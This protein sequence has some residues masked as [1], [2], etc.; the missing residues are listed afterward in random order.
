MAQKSPQG[1]K[2]LSVARKPSQDASLAAPAAA[3]VAAAADQTPW[4][5]RKLFNSPF[6]RFSHAASALT[7]DQGAVYLMGGLS[8][9]AVYGDMWVIEPIKQSKGSSN[10]TSKNF[11][12]IASPIENFERVPSPRT[13]HASVLI[14]NAFIVFGGD[15]VID[16]N[17]QFLDNKLYFF[18]ISSLK[19]TITS[20]EGE[21][22]LGRYGHQISVLNFEHQNKPNQWMSYLYLFGGQMDDTYFN[23]MW[24]FD[25]S[26]FRNPKT[27]WESI[28]TRGEVPPPLANHSLVAYNNK[29]F[30]YGGNNGSI[31]NDKMYVFDPID[32]TWKV[33][34]FHGKFKPPPLTEH[35]VAIYQNLL[36][37]FGGKMVNDQLSNDL[38]II[39]LN[40]MNSFKILSDL[41]MCP[42]PRCGHSISVN[43]NDQKII[44]MGGDKYDDDFSGLEV[45]QLDSIDESQFSYK[46]SVI[47]EFDINKLDEFMEKASSLPVISSTPLSSK[48]NLDLTELPDTA[49]V[50]QKQAHRT[51][52]IKSEH[53]STEFIH[54]GEEDDDSI[55]PSGNPSGERIKSMDTHNNEESIFNDYNDIHTD[56]D[57][58]KT[59]E[60]NEEDNEDEENVD[61]FIQNTPATVQTNLSDS[62]ATAGVTDIM[63]TPTNNI[64]N[65]SN[66][67]DRIITP[68]TAFTNI[69]NSGK[70]MDISPVD[71]VELKSQATAAPLTPSMAHLIGTPST[72]FSPAYMER[73]NDKM[74]KLIKMVN[75]L[76]FDLNNKVAKAD[77][78]IKT[79]SLENEELRSKQLSTSSLGIDTDFNELN[80]LI[81]AQQ[82]KIEKMSSLLISEDSK[83]KRINEL[84]TV[85]TQLLKENEK[86]KLI[87]EKLLPDEKIQLI[88]EKLEEL[89]ISHQNQSKELESNESKVLELE[90]K[91]K[92]TIGSLNKTYKALHLS[93]NELG[94]LR[95]E[96]K[97]LKNQIE[98]LKISKRVYSNSST[99]LIDNKKQISRDL[100]N[101]NREPGQ[102][103]EEDDDDEND[104]DPL[105]IK[106]K[107]LEAHLYIV[108]QERDDL[109]EE[110]LT[111]KKQMYTSKQTTKY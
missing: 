76:K 78:R 6:P 100:V 85:N 11:P 99:P 32:Y 97:M 73:D 28:Q 70:S 110:L 38:F 40:S 18:N 107:D 29:L 22:P 46:S 67:A 36:F 50:E 68:V 88:S 89:S 62:T 83:D 95:E 58:D 61:Q 109:K 108:S 72:P 47:F 94:K 15:T 4:K 34:K 30:I 35:S 63:E 48:S 59:L 56:D 93:Q 39:D 2:Q 8:H 20:P 10:G 19:W 102:H 43:A 101:E 81:K 31:I 66:P 55:V 87:Q 74:K 86:F 17:D 26:N 104:L 103:D 106:L 3:T 5:K 111:I 44:V 105:V 79:L 42:A 60:D 84:E 69:S 24:K 23:D 12:Y 52:F 91:Q 82:L 33:N 57:H 41:P 54:T 16:A 92:E 27:V 51:S 49:N 7:S 65:T 77:E 96:N 75:D 71:K 80:E 13:G 9:N 14:G 98:E 25:L 45:D 90:N 21:R 64:R 1:A 53:G 37:I